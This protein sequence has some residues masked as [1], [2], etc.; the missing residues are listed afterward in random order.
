LTSLGLEKFNKSLQKI[1]SPG[2][3]EPYLHTVASNIRLRQRDGIPIRV[4]PVS[5]PRRYPQLT[6]GSEHLPSDDQLALRLEGG[7]VK[8]NQPD[9]KSHGSGHW[10]I[11]SIQKFFY[12]EKRSTFKRSVV[13]MMN[14]I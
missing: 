10:K 2:Q 6:R 1:S 3:W 9:T 5:L 7:N 13:C 12:Q 11:T 14:G 8:E 4:Q